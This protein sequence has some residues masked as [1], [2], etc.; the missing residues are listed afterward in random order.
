M[1]I[2]MSV[3]GQQI[4]DKAI[5]GTLIDLYGDDAPL[6]IVQALNHKQYLMYLKR[7]TYWKES[8]G[9]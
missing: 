1:T 3:K 7:A 2:P 9:A 6:K 4:S 5:V 8:N